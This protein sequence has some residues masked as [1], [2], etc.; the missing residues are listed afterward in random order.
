VAGLEAR[1]S[2]VAVSRRLGSA[3]SLLCGAV[4]RFNAAVKDGYEELF[5]RSY[6]EAREAF[7]AAARAHPH[8]R[9]QGALSITPEHTIDW[10]F[11]GDEAARDVLVYTSGLH[12]IEGYPGSAVQR[13]LLALGEPRAVLW[14]HALNPWGM[15]HY[16]RV[17]ES[18]VDLNRNFMADGQ[19]YRADD[20]AYAKLDGL[21]NPKRA[22]GIDLF[23]LGAGVSLVR[24]GM[25]ALRNAIAR[26]QYSFAKG[27]FYGGSAPE[28]TT[29]AIL[30]FLPERLAK[31]RRVVHIDLHTA[32]GPRGD[33]VAF[34]ENGGG[35]ERARAEPIFERRLRAWEAGSA[36]GYDMR[37]GMLPALIR[38]AKSDGVRYDAIT[39]EFGTSTDLAI[40]RALRE[41]NQR[42]FYGD[43]A[44]QSAPLPSMKSAFYPDDPAWRRAVV[45]HA[46]DIHERATRLLATG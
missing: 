22:P 12:G 40:L 39:L 6:P 4:S 17:N 24:Y 44:S 31:A 23:L 25:S 10:A 7:R 1:C 38:R 8:L 36:D 35:D 14:L 9:E 30:G 27:L 46:T 33:Y 20:E 29:R 37:G 15:A 11:T 43:P 28:A 45:G 41:E 21:L 34:L 2:R 18:N 32:R 5:A 42:F 16:R 13:R 3:S 19:G 26:G